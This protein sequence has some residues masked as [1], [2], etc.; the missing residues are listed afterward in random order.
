METFLRIYILPLRRLMLLYTHSLSHTLT[1]IRYITA[2]N[3]KAS[4]HA[5]IGYRRIM[6]TASVQQPQVKLC[7]NL[8]QEHHNRDVANSKFPLLLD[9]SALEEL[10]FT[11]WH[12]SSVPETHARVLSKHFWTALQYVVENPLSTLRN[13]SVICPAEKTN[14]LDYGKP[15]AEPV[16]GLLHTLVEQQA[17]LTPNANAIQYE[18]GEAPITYA[19]F[20]MRATRLA[21]QLAPCRGFYIPVC[22]HRST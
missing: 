19:A 11:M 12:N 6:E 3:L 18:M 13:V 7:I 5:F 2:A 8:Q 1:W 16:E 22:M 4:A 9:I 10:R 14:I 21:R 15:A 20:N 17:T